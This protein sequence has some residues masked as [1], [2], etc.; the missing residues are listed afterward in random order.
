MAHDRG[1]QTSDLQVG[2]L[3]RAFDPYAPHM[4]PERG[5]KVDEL[6]ACEE[7]QNEKSVHCNALYEYIVVMVAQL[8]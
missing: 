7:I 6:F 2:P 3:K 1:L 5:L 4:A 8:V